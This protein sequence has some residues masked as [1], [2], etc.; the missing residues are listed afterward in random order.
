VLNLVS[1]AALNYFS[2]AVMPGIHR[3]VR[4]NQSVL[5]SRESCRAALTMTSAPVLVLI[6]FI[7]LT[8]YLQR[9][10]LPVALL[11]FFAITANFQL[12]ACHIILYK[13]T[14]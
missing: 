14:G 10:L 6:H 5:L 1:S 11:R 8:P 3:K 9:G 12:S 7:K 4:L 13:A 2:L